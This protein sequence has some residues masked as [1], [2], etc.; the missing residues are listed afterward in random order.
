MFRC[1]WQNQQFAAVKL[2]KRRNNVLHLQNL[3]S[4]FLF[5][6][7]KNKKAFNQINWLDVTED[8]KIYVEC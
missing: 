5:K 1:E 7:E 2:P 8:I 6:A 4:T 3:Y